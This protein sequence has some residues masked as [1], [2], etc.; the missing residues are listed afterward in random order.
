MKKITNNLL[1]LK[2]VLALITILYLSYLY[3]DFFSRYTELSASMKFISIVLCFLLALLSGAKPFN[4]YNVKLLKIGLFL[5]VIADFFLLIEKE[6][7]EIGITVFSIAQ[8]IYTIRYNSRNRTNIIRSYVILLFTLFFTY[9][10][11]KPFTKIEIIIPIALFYGIALI[12]NVYKA[13]VVYRE[14]LY[15]RPNGLMVALGM[16]LFLLCD[17]NVLLYNIFRYVKQTNGLLYRLSHV[18]IWLYYLPSQVLLAL[19]GYKF[20][21]SDS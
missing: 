3:M 8:I 11:I 6:H 20:K 7:Y 14:K 1:F 17:I 12:T 21:E 18:S 4:G 5:T 19:S 15:P 2:I 10:V 16:L 13:F 9:I